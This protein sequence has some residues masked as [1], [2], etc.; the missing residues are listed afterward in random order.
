MLQGARGFK[1]GTKPHAINL[2]PL[3]PQCGFSSCVFVLGRVH[4]IDLERL[5]QGSAGEKSGYRC[6]G[7]G[8][9]QRRRPIQRCL[10]RF[11]PPTDRNGKLHGGKCWRFQL[12]G[13][14][15]HGDSR[16]WWR[17]SRRQYGFHLFG[18]CH[19]HTIGLQWLSRSGEGETGQSQSRP[20]RRR[21][22]R[23]SR[24]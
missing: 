20:R 2:S 3:G 18:W 17:R 24:R 12:H 4:R 21:R 8:G 11:F 14:R 22:Y 10:Q 6:R 9:K 23:G 1:L 15:Q 16:W 19:G 7:G 5:H 13:L